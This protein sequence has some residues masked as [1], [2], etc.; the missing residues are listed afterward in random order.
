MIR[1]ENVALDE[2]GIILI[3][4][5][6]LLDQISAGHA[7]EHPNLVATN[8]GSCMNIADCSHTLNLGVCIP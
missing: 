2:R 5:Q 6:A 4:D 1:V 8:V 3:N 7:S